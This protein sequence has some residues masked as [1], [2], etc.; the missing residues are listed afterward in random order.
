MKALEKDKLNGERT[1]GTA[2]YS[3]LTY[4]GG[5]F[6]HTL[7]TIHCDKGVV[8][9]LT[10][11]YHDYLSGRSEV[12]RFPNPG[13]GDRRDERF[14]HTKISDLFVRYRSQARASPSENDIYYDTLKD[15]LVIRILQLI[16]REGI[17]ASEYPLVVHLTTTVQTLEAH[18]LSL[19]RK[20]LPDSVRRAGGLE[21]E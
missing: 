18:F 13:N 4:D 11:Q 19:L 21:F 5:R 9:G 7:I 20:P 14:V 1:Q 17:E 10:Y 8:R 2:Y 16:N 6:D 15:F 3:M 12:A